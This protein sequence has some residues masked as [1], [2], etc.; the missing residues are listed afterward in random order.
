MNLL[1]GLIP[2]ALAMGLLAPIAG[3]VAGVYLALALNRRA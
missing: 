3:I 2:L 1:L